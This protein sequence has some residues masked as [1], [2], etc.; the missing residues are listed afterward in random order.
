[1]AELDLSQT[2]L[3]RVGV[4]V[5]T[6]LGTLDWAFDQYESLQSGGYKSEHPYTIAAGSANAVSGE[7]SAEF[8]FRGPSL[9]FSQGC[10]SASMAIAYGLDLIQL[11]RV[12]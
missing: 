12:D 5:G 1:D 3:D 11:G 2:N 9:T 4:A 6:T 8:G 7:M 10:S